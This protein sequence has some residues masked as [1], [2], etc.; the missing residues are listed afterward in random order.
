MTEQ[1][2]CGQP[3][4]TPWGDPSCKAHRSK[5]GT[6]CRA[7]PV[8]GAAVC[9]KHGGSIGAVKRRAAARVAEAEIERTMGDLLRQDSC[10]QGIV[11]RRRSVGGISAAASRR[12]GGTGPAR[13]TA[14]RRAVRHGPR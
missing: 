2:H 11:L 3:H 9:T 12:A 10:A 4:I 8:R 6:A 5:T 1:C 14:W 13:G 7:N